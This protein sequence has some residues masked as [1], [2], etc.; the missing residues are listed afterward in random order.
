MPPGKDF[1]CIAEVIM[2]AMEN[3]RKK[4]VGSI[5]INHLRETEKWGGIWIY[6]EGVNE[7][8]TTS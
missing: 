3:E 4:H 6:V 7:F 1:A 2:Q 8:W 5:D